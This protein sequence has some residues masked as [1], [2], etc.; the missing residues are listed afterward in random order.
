MVPLT[1]TPL[2]GVFTATTA[3]DLG[4]F[5]MWGVTAAKRYQYLFLFPIFQKNFASRTRRGT[6][7]II[8]PTTYPP[9]I[10]CEIK[11][12]NFSQ[13]RRKNKKGEKRFRSTP[14]AMPLLFGAHPRPRLE[15][16]CQSYRPGLFP[17]LPPREINQFSITVVLK[18]KRSVKLSLI[19]NKRMANEEAGV[20][21]VTRAG[22]LRVRLHSLLLYSMPS[23]LRP[24]GTAPG[25]ESDSLSV[26]GWEARRMRQRVIPA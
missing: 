17:R 11:R 24:R 7:E 6:E 3:S 25:S 10:V 15:W 14:K 2:S 12:W 23:V 8:T 13:T 9:S 1:Q 22:I 19:N 16:I 5:G 26:E 4:C 18:D 21:G 20:Y